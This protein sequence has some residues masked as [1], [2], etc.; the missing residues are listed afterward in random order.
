M[1]PRRRAAAQDGFFPVN[2]THPDELAEAVAA[3]T[4]LRD[5]PTSPY[6]YVVALE[7]DTDPA[8]YV[9]A[10]ATWLLTD[11]DPHAV[12]LAAVRSLVRAGP[13]HG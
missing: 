5:D 10:G 2:L 7:P 13:Q 8:P 12:T 6:D 4:A 3:I 9:D 1:R 11:L